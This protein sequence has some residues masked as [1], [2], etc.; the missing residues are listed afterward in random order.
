M[1]CVQCWNEISKIA[2]RCIVCKEIFCSQ[3]CLDEHTKDVREDLERQARDAEYYD[4][5]WE[6]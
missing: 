2:Y 5:E 3:S 1:Q 6:R 4:S